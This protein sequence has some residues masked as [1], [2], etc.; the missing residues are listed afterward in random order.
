MPQS[1]V[2]QQLNIIDPSVEA[3]MVAVKTQ[4]CDCY[5]V[6]MHVSPRMFITQKFKESGLKRVEFDLN[7]N[8]LDFI[9]DAER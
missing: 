1:R 6:H 3:S 9:F 8:S 7:R 4:R 5:L 2:K